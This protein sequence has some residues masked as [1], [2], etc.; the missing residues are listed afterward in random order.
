[1][2]KQSK[3]DVH[4]CSHQLG[5]ISSLLLKTTGCLGTANVDWHIVQSRVQTVTVLAPNLR[6]F[7][8]KE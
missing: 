2:H 7:P 4:V 8:E 5:V 3:A 6:T 1:M